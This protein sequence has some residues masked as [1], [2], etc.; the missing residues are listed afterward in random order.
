MWNVNIKRGAIWSTKSINQYEDNY[1]GMTAGTSLILIVNAFIDEYG[2]RKIVYFKISNICP[3]LSL[4]KSIIINNYT[5]YIVLDNI[6]T[7]QQEAL[8]SFV[9]NVSSIEMTDIIKTANKYFNLTMHTK[10]IETKNI[11]TKNT[12]INSCQRRIYKFGI[13]IYVTEND[14]VTISESN[15]LILSE[16]A[17]QDIIYN[18]KTDEDIRIL[19]DKYMIYPA[20]AIRNIRNRLVYQ[21]KQKEG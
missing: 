8:D 18:S 14:N 19:C 4:T 15:K 2:N 1:I 10:N 6:F 20:A 21:H 13:D 17:K 3:K 7:G 5:K 9:A 11:E 16:S 12:A